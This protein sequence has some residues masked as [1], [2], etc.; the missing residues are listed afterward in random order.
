MEISYEEAPEMNPEAIATVLFADGHD[1]KE[2]G[3]W[4]IIGEGIDNTQ[5]FEILLII[6]LEGLEKISGGLNTINVN[7]LTDD[8]IL[9]INP[10]FNSIGYKIS[11]QHGTTDAHHCKVTLRNDMNDHVFQMRHIDKNYHFYLNS[12]KINDTYGDLEN[13]CATLEDTDII[14]NFDH[15][16]EIMTAAQEIN[17]LGI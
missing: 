8:H 4:T 14:I 10:W 9:F 16:I 7:E 12:K 6:L 17:K 3:F 13:V 1:P 11:I 5:C 15:H 2:A